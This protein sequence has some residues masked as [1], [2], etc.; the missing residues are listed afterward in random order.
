MIGCISNCVCSNLQKISFVFVTTL[1]LQAIESYSVC[2]LQRIFFFFFLSVKSCWI[3]REWEIL[4][5][6]YLD[7]A[8]PKYSRIL[9]LKI[10][11]PLWSIAKLKTE[12]KKKP[13]STSLIC[14]SGKKIALLW[15]WNWE[16]SGNIY[17]YF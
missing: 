9:F 10:Y 11:L 1:R 14:F 2:L 4:K 5:L 12:V 16:N 17:I 13:W 7:I 15:E 8:L 3:L 6:P